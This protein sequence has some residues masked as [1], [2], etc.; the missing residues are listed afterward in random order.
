MITQI[1][2]ACTDKQRLVRFFPLLHPNQKGAELD[3][4]IIQ[5]RVAMLHLNACLTEHR[6][7]CY[8]LIASPK[9]IYML[10]V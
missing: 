8:K 7:L 10:A 2:K 9:F 5:G 1:G 4:T 6:G 3:C